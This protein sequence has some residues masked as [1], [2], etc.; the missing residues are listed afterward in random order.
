[1]LQQQLLTNGV[2]CFYI[3]KRTTIKKNKKRCARCEKFKPFSEFSKRKDKYLN[4]GTYC[5]ICERLR[6]DEKE[7]RVQKKDPLVF[8]GRHFRSYKSSA[9]KR[10][11]YFNLDKEF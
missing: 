7:I 9:K 11:I 2:D 10:G 3:K 6:Q 5:K 1:M 4:L 8:I